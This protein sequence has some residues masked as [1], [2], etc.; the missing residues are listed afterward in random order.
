MKGNRARL[1]DGAN[2]FN[3]GKFWKDF[4]WKNLIPF[5]AI[6]T[7]CDHTMLHVMTIW[8]VYLVLL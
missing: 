7:L 6:G 5:M 1:P 3:F 8:Y 4:E 2:T